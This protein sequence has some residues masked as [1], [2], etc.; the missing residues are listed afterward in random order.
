YVYKKVDQ[1]MILLCMISL[2]IM[3]P[4]SS[5]YFANPSSSSGYPAAVSYFV[6]ASIHTYITCLSLPGTGTPQSKVVRETERSRS[7][8]A[9]KEAISLRREAGPTN[10]GWA[11][12]SSSSLSWYLDRPSKS[13]SVS[14]QATSVWVSL[15]RR[16]PSTTSVSSCV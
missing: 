15:D 4:S 16:T 6:S 7:P 9:T 14:V 10:S 11:S 8:E 13:D 1:C 12:Y 3:W 5:H 2:H